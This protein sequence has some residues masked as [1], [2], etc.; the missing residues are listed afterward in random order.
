MRGRRRRHSPSRDTGSAIQPGRVASVMEAE[1]RDERLQRPALRSLAEDHQPRGATV[2]DPSEGAQERPEVLLPREPPHRDH[3]GRFARAEPRM[4]ERGR[5]P[6][7]SARGSRSGCGP[8]RSARGANRSFE[9]GHPPSL[10]RRTRSG[11]PRDR[12]VRSAWAGA[13]AVGGVNERPRGRARSARSRRAGCPPGPGPSPRC[14]RRSRSSSMSASPQAVRGGG[15]GSDPGCSPGRGWHPGPRSG[16]YRE[17][18]RDSG[19]RRRLN[20]RSTSYPR[21]AIPPAS[22]AIARSA[23][24]PSML[25]VKIATRTLPFDAPL[26]SVT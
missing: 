24:P 5:P 15:T 3:D 11:P 17:P 18:R 1:L 7:P 10:E 6:A 21:S 23:P 20:T 25:D 14:R 2:A 22:L 26:R 16:P 8:P 13:D 19:P 12:S 9:R 4:I